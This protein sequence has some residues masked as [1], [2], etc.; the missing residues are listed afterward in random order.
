MKTQE[1]NWVLSAL[2]LIFIV[3][4]LTGVIDWSWWY[5]TM[6]LWG[7]LALLALIFGIMFIFALI[8]V[9]R[10]DKAEK[11]QIVKSQFIDDPEF[12]REG[13]FKKLD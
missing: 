11:R 10:E 12:E 9:Y 4:K 5:I 13:G 6:P 2:G 3:L 7:G 8:K 1:S